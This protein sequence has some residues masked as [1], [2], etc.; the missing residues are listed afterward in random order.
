MRYELIFREISAF[1]PGEAEAFVLLLPEV[2]RPQLKCSFPVPFFY[3]IFLGL[4]VEN[5]HKR[6]ICDSVC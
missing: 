1:R 2:Q 3:L 5:G 6:V 4:L